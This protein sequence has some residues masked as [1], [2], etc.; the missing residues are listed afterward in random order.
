MPNRR[1]IEGRPYTGA[2][3]RLEELRDDLWNRW[4]DAYDRRVDLADASHSGERTVYGGK[5]LF[6]LK[7]YT[8][9]SFPA[10]GRILF[11]QPA[12]R[13]SFHLYRL[14]AMGRPVFTHARHEVNDLDWQGFYCYT[15]DEVEYVEFCLQ[16]NVVSDYAR[17]TLHNGLPATYQHIDISGGGSHIGQHTGRIAMDF[18]PQD[19]HFYWVDVEKYESSDGRIVS[20]KSLV[21][22]N[23]LSAMRSSLA[24]SWSANGKL[25][26]IVSTNQDG[27]E[28]TIYAAPTKTSMKELAASLSEQI[29][30][31]AIEALQNA[32]LGAPLVAV[33]LSYRSVTDYLPIVIAATE[34]DSVPSL[35]LI[36]AIDPNQWINLKHG[37]FEPGMTEFVQRLSADER[38]DHAE[39]M[40]RH[41]ARL[42]TSRAPGSLAT[43]DS[44]VAFAIDWEFDGHELPAILKECGASL[45]TLEKLKAKGWL[46]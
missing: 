4:R 21:E 28:C 5:P 31:R 29:A 12:G 45:A 32:V 9:N 44:F 22:G 27:Y 37:D 46:D 17:M 16:T 11:I 33:E 40:L 6:S 1:A 26:R 38:Y 7:Q 3:D 18:I 10:G 8:P 35:V 19:S 42:I 24:Y 39:K 25:E 20:G 14:N 15:P 41:A 13:N 2:V 30:A 34:R 23:G 36:T 43:S